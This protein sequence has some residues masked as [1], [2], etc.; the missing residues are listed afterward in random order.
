MVRIYHDI[1]GVDTSKIQLMLRDTPG[2][3][4]ADES[5]QR[6]L[7]EKIFYDIDSLS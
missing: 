3:D 1:P 7:A 6:Q 4:G 5:R 2:P